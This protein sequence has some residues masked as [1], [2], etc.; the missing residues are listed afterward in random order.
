[1]AD[2][3]LYLYDPLCG[4][5]YGASAG[6]RTLAT[7]ADVTVEVLPTGLFARPDAGPLSEQ[8]AQHIWT[9][10]RRIAEMTGAVFSERYHDLLAARTPLDSTLATLA[11]TAVSLHAP[12]RELELLAVI[13][14]A[15]YVDGRD[16]TDMAVLV[17]LLK[18]V[19]LSM[20]A[21]TLVQA[22]PALVA[23]DAA[24]TRRASELLN[25]FDARGVPTVLR[26]TGHGLTLVDTRAVYCNP[27]SLL[28][29]AVA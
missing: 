25:R 3:F 16:I 29:E 10:D 23:A 27:L 4:W 21:S 14:T 12:Q 28:T 2:Q 22:G 7:L 6:M 24:R 8:M 19:D 11:L 18:S 5:C 1:M 13:Q 26:D 20:A 17:N 9:S 15:R